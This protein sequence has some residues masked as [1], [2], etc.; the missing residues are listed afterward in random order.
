MLAFNGVRHCARHPQVKLVF[1]GHDR[2]F[3]T[4]RFLCPLCGTVR[5]YSSGVIKHINNVRGFF[6]I[7]NGCGQDLFAHVNDLATAFV[8]RLGQAVEFEVGHSAK[9]PKALAIRP[10]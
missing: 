1:S 6:F 7:E 8:L 2:R 5:E 3:N 4:T 9:G 10:L